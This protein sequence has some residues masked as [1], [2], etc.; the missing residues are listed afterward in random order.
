MNDKLDGWKMILV[1]VLL[2]FPA[3]VIGLLLIH[4]I[5]SITGSTLLGYLVGV[6]VASVV[7][8]IP[9]IR[10]VH[11]SKKLQLAVKYIVIILVV[12]LFM[13]GIFMMTKT[14]NSQ[15]KEF[16]RRQQKWEN[17]KSEEWNGENK[18]Y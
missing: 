12:F 16:Q 4:M 8:A 15:I 1:C 7:L 9:I 18:V 5:E 13:G 6:L 10:L 17:K 11:K 2:L 14:P 3:L